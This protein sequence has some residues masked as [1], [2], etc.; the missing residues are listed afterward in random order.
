MFSINL[1][2]NS[3]YV[4]PTASNNLGYI[5]IFVKPGIVLISLIYILLVPS[6]I[7]K[8]TLAKPLPSIDLNALIAF[9]W[10]SSISFFS[11]LAGIIVWEFGMLYFASKL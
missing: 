8:S 5:L 10:I 2:S 3:V 6:S 7:K 1:S 9:F 4:I 11:I